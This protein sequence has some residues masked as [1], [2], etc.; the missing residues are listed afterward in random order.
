VTSWKRAAVTATVIALAGTGLWVGRVVPAPAEPV[1]PVGAAPYRVCPVAEAGGGFSSRLGLYR[2]GDTQ[3][4]LGAVGGPQLAQTFLFSESFAY[5]TDVGELAELGLTPLLI[6][7][8]AAGGVYNR[9]GDASAVSGCVSATADPVAVLGMAT[10]GGE[11]SILILTNPFAVEASVQLEAV[12]E[13]GI[14]T[15]TDLEQVRIPAATSLELDFNQTLAGRETLSFAVTPLSGSV[16]AGMRR[17]GEGDVAASEAIAGS[18]VWYFALPDFGI[19]G[20][21]HLRALAEGDTAFRIDRIGTDVLAEAVAEGTITPQAVASFELV[22]LG[23]EG[24]GFVLS[25]D[26]PIA[27]AVVYAG[28]ESLAVS[29]GVDMAATSWAVPVSSLR[30]EGRTALWLLNTTDRQLTGTV[31]SLNRETTRTIA[32]PPGRTTGM[33]RD[34]LGGS[35]ALVTADGPIAAFYGIL[36]GSAVGMSAATPLE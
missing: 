26:Q 15:P 14:D 4:R 22:D 10:S 12:S 20:A 30:T 16:V 1:D 35:G 17:A 23:A 7:S 33:L 28:A 24:G 8:D 6:E 34:D 9:A 11:T 29:A 18:T 3:G 13:F 2:D 31:R 32:L 21:I 25:S 27:A 5:Q 36:S 19:E